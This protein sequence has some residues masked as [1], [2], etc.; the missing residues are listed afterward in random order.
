MSNDYLLPSLMQAPP[1]LDPASKSTHPSC[2]ELLDCQRFLT[3]SSSLAQLRFSAGVPCLSVI[4]VL[5]HPDHLVGS[6]CPCSVLV[7]YISLSLRFGNM[8]DI[9]I[10]ISERSSGWT[11]NCSGSVLVYSQNR[12]QLSWSQEQISFCCCWVPVFGTGTLHKIYEFLFLVKFGLKAK[13]LS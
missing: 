3:Q 10:Q 8:I 6:N 9:E 5:R 1:F 13:I 4:W 12:S 2:S 11:T 7:Y